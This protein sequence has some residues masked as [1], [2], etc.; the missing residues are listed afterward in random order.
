MSRVLQVPKHKLQKDSQVQKVLLIESDRLLA[1]NI[2]KVLR[3]FSYEVEWQVDAQEALN[4]VDAK[5]PNLIILDLLLANRG[6]VEFLY[7]F[8]SY[9]DWQAVPIVVFSSL[10]AEEL[11]EALNGFEHINISAYHY[12][13]SSALADLVNTTNRILHSAAA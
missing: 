3:S 2:L 8:R 9:P 5:M 1:E 10:S 11:K 6:G 4:S 12:K 13:S 7:E